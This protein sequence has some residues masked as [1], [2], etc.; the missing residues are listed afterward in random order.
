MRC[1]ICKEAVRQPNNH[2]QCT[3]CK[4]ITHNGCASVNTSLFYCI[5][6]NR[7][8]FPF[9]NINN[10]ELDNLFEMDIYELIGLLDHVNWEERLPD[11]TEKIEH[12]NYYN[13]ENFRNLSKN[14]H[15]NDFLLLHMNI[16]SLNSRQ[17]K[18]ENLIHCIDKLPDLIGV[19][20]TKIRINDNITDAYNIMNL[21]ITTHLHTLEVW[22]FM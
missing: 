18:L 3:V 13:L 19:S 20:E 12:C 5:N 14:L 8:I 21:F 1:N 11:T 6:C 9:Q 22:D 15:K 4:N 7:D 2:L 16:V 17:Y 10:D